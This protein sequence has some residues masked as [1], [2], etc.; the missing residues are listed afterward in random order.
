MNKTYA[1]DW[2]CDDDYSL[3]QDKE[4]MVLKKILLTIGVLLG[5][6]A[7]GV[8]IWF[9]GFVNPRHY[10]ADDF[11]NLEHAASAAV[12]LRTSGERGELPFDKWPLVYK[13]MGAKAVRVYP[14]GVIVKSHGMFTLESGLYFPSAAAAEKLHS[15]L[16][17]DDRH[18]YVVEGIYSYRLK[19]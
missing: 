19:D 9:F 6:A 8:A 13:E 4:I 2:G 10:G 12:V 11:S 16:E 14:T 3:A 17:H 1:A 18:K 7:G 5:L 15:R